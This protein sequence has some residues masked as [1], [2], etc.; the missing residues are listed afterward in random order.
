MNKQWNSPLGRMR[1]G[2]VIIRRCLFF[3]LL[4]SVIFLSAEPAAAS[5]T[6]ELPERAT[7]Q[8]TPI[9]INFNTY[10]PTPFGSEDVNP[11]MTIED[12]GNT[13]H[14]TGNSWKKISLP[15]TVT[16]YTVIEFDFKSPVQGEVHG[17]G[18]DDNQ[19]IS[20]GYTHKLYGT[21]T[22]GINVPSYRYASFAPN[23]RHYRI[24]IGEEYTGNMLYLVFANDHDVSNPTGE[25]YFSN[26]QVF[27]DPSLPAQPPVE[28]DFG[29]YTISPYAGSSESPALN[30]T[31]E[32]NGGALHMVGNGWQKMSLPYTVTSNTVIEFDYKSSAQGE[33]Q[34]IGFDADNSRQTEQT[35]Q[36]YG[37]DAW[38]LN[39]FQYTGYA[40]GW[41]HFRIPVGKYYTGT[42]RYI[43]F[44]NDHDISNPTSENYFRNLSVYEGEVSLPVTVDFNQYALSLYRSPM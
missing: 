19:S 4:L 14:L 28:V 6:R 22:W 9:Q 24:P 41:K 23:W 38:G 40:P 42:M 13:L 8:F 20:S 36:L 16:A 11:T 43:F 44:V 32:D 7:A 27:E 21:Q 15:Y 3:A 37:T 30:L 2:K 5:S 35:F 1:Q 39:A 12:G 10:T 17:I 31:I 25:S 18:F 26:V 33:V 29:N 34:G